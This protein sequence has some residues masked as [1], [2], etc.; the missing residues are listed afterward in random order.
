MA[1]CAHA[2]QTIGSEIEALSELT[3]LI[4]YNTSVGGSISFV[5][6]LNKLNSLVLD[7]TNVAGALPDDIYD[8]PFTQFQLSFNP[9]ITGTLR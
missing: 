9:R 6:K 1:Q 7:F 4:L 8:R 3:N 5:K 2:A